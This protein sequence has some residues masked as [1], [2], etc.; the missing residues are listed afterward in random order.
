MKLEEVLDKELVDVFESIK[1]KITENKTLKKYIKIISPD[2]Y[3]LSRGKRYSLHLTLNTV[4]NSNKV[5]SELKEIIKSYLNYKID[6]KQ[7]GILIE[8]IFYV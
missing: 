7:N 1:K 6:I 5:I 3:V 8:I 4:K 2:V